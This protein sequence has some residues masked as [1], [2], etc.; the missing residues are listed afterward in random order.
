MTNKRNPLIPD[1][2]PQQDMFVCNIVDASPKA[3]MGSMEH[4]VF[5]LSRKPDMKPCE[6]HNSDTFIRVS[7]SAKGLATVA[8]S[9]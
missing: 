4:P 1:R 6:Y 9:E 7:P 5:S 2:H 3:D 8:L